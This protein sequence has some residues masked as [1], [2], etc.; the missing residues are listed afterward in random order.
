MGKEEFLRELGVMLNDAGE[1]AP[2]VENHNQKGK[3]NT[4]YQADTGDDVSRQLSS[5]GKEVELLKQQ[6]ETMQGEIQRIGKL[7]NVGRTIPKHTHEELEQAMNKLQ[8]IPK[9]IHPGLQKQISGL[10]ADIGDMRNNI[11]SVLKEHK[12]R[13]DGLEKAKDEKREEEEPFSI[14]EF[15]RSFAPFA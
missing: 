10:S 14:A 5:L 7:Q 6:I 13:I 2:T 1:Q 8:G 9:H 12:S 11:E 15:V 4:R 3:S